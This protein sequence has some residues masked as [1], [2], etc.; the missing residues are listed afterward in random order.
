MSAQEKRTATTDR[1]SDAVRPDRRV[2]E[3]IRIGVLT[4]DQA[5][6]V[7]EEQ[8]R[9]RRSLPRVLLDL[10]FVAEDDLPRV[11]AAWK[12]YDFIDL[13]DYPVD[14]NAALMIPLSMARRHTM[15]PI[16]F[17]GEKLVVALADPTNV[18]L[19][20]DI[21]IL[22][23]REVKVVVATSRDIIETLTRFEA[24]ESTASGLLEEKPQEITDDDKM[25]AAAVEDAP[26]V[27]AVNRIITQAVQ[28]RASDVHVEPEERDLRIRYR[29]DGVLHDV[30]RIPQIH[31]AGVISRLK[32]MA[33]ANIAEKRLPQD[34]RVTVT[35]DGKPI[36]LRVSTL[37]SVWGEEVSIRVLDRASSLL[38]LEDMGFSAETRKRYEE[39]AKKSYGALLVTGPTGSGKST[40]LYATLNLL[41]DA[42]K[43]I[44]TVEDPV[45]YRLPGLRQM[46]V[47]PYIGLTFATFLRSILRSDPDILMV[48]EIRDRETATMAVHAA[49][50]GH[51]ILS[52]L[53]TN[54]A[55]T[56]ATRLVEM[57]VEPFLIASALEAVMAQRL[58][59]RVCTRC[60]EDYSPE[61][62]I[63]RAAGFPL[64][65]GPPPALKRPVGCRACA[66]TGYR[67][68]VALSELLIVTEEIERLIAERASTEVIA[69]V[70]REQGMQS[71]QE[72]GMEKAREGITTIEE[73]L[74]V[75]S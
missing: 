30:M 33:D 59:R 36:D 58:A 66:D 8:R 3:L 17:D 42:T 15:V 4:E 26:I 51:L 49:M 39:A 54:D 40:T 10:G 19:L 20:D 28:Q 27:K 50:T 43:K 25:A 13:H 9:T 23:D 53:H 7:I 41:N 47:H 35:V 14:Q 71:L 16:G 72:D 38:T 75:T 67:G 63:L 1:D 34:G 60:A 68:R 29:I 12:G 46:Q 6:Q 61:R 22:T 64:D 44:I 74:R 2:A 55:P 24:L 5:Q 56:A 37:P 73:V 11:L 48:G 45:E 69:H 57:G 21:R 62:S 31:Q 52:T 70:A 18:I 32:V 65:D